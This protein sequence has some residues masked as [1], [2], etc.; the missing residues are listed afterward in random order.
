MSSICLCFHT[1]P[2]VTSAAQKLSNAD[3]LIALHSSRLSHGFLLK[4]GASVIE[5][6]PLGLKRTAPF[7]EQAAAAAAD[8]E[9]KLLWWHLFVCDPDSSVPGDHEVQ[10]LKPKWTWSLYR[11]VKLSWAALEAVLEQVVAVQG[12]GRRYEELYQSNSH[13][14]YMINADEK[15][16]QGTNDDSRDQCAVGSDPE[17]GSGVKIDVRTIH[18]NFFV[19]ELFKTLKH[20]FK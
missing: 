10:G 5:V 4:P 1:A 19:C 8:V 3:I 17:K 11:S 18:Q 20:Q 7:A 2:G 6:L 9:S 14:F 15:A 12:N 16:R 13:S